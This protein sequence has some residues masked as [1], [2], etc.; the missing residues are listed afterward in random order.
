M[1]G[2]REI[3]GGDDDLPGLRERSGGGEGQDEEGCRQDVTEESGCFHW[4]ACREWRMD[5]TREG[6]WV[7]AGVPPNIQHPTSN[8]QHPTSNPAEPE[9]RVE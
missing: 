3:G 2:G 5:S 9:P 4:G 7:L 6:L 1:I 8:I